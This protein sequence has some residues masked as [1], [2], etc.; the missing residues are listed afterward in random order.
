MVPQYWSPLDAVQV[1]GVQAA[2]GAWHRPSWQTQPGFAQA[3]GQFKECP[4]PSPTTPQY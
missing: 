2:A 4:H 3:A 1:S